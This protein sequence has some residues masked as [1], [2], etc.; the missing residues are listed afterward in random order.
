MKWWFLNYPPREMLIHYKK[1]GMGI[2]YGGLAM[3][4]KFE[5]YFIYGK[6][7]TAKFYSNVWDVPLRAGFNRDRN[8]VH[9]HPK[10]YEV[11]SK[12]ISRLKPKSVIDPFL[13]SGTTAEV[14]T[15][16]GIPWLGYELNMAF[17]VDINDRL[18]YCKKEPIQTFL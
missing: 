17:A 11:W 8:T 2:S 10:P 4:N 14:C 7:R 3:T 9:P 5:P 16:L 12:I 15:K 18:R 13:G 6:F 1:N